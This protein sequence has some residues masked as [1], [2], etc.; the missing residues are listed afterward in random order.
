MIH[1]FEQ[2]D[3]NVAQVAGKQI[4]HDLPSAVH[5]AFVSKTPSFQQQK[6]GVGFVALANKVRSPGLAAAP[7]ARRE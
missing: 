7:S 4:S 2:E 5:H 3:L 6:H 1:F